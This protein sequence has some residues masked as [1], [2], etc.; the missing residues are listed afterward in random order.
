MPRTW[1]LISDGEVIA[2]GPSIM[3]LA[4]IAI[5]QEL[6]WWQNMTPKLRHGTYIVPPGMAE[7]I[8][9]TGVCYG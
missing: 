5:K 3:A 9:Q 1:C 4:D 6:G 7:R 8:E 2:T